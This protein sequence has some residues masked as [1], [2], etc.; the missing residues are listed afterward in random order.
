MEKLIISLNAVELR[1][2]GIWAEAIL[3][4]GH[5]GDG[6]VILPDEEAAMQLLKS[7]QANSALACTPRSIFTFLVWSS[8]SSETP[9]EQI[10]REKLEKSLAGTGLRPPVL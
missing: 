2:L 9:E 5:W 8:A 1:I 7:A 4:G 10:L 3:H 6:A